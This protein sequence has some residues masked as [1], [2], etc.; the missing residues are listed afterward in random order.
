MSRIC[1]ISG[2]KA[3]SGHNVSHS[4]IKTKRRFLPNLQEVSFFSDTL[5]RSVGM[6]VC[7]RGAKSVEKKGGI[8]AYLLSK[9]SSKLTPEARALKAKIQAASSKKAGA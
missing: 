7:A 9:G 1:E 8:D 2:K 3:Q 5:K 6:K 4:E